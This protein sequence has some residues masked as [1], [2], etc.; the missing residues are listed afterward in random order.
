MLWSFDYAYLLVTF[1][2]NFGF[3]YCLVYDSKFELV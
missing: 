1:C 2:L 3:G